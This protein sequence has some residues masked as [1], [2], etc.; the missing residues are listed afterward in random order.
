MSLNDHR[1]SA[2]AFRSLMELAQRDISSGGEI[3]PARVLAVKPP[4][5]RRRPRLRPVE[6]LRKRA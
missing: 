1:G 5:K 2:W 3:K 4:R 6:L